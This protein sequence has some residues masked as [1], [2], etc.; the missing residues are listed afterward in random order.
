MQVPERPFPLLDVRFQGIDG[1][2]V[3][4]PARLHFIN[5]LSNERIAPLGQDLGEH[6]LLKILEQ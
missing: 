2:T 4:H 1:R 3:L 6:H 5:F